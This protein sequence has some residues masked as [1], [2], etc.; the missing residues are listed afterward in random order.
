MSDILEAFLLFEESIK[1]HFIPVQAAIWDALFD[2]QKEKEIHGDL[3]EIGVLSGKSAV[4]LAMNSNVHEEVHLV[5]IKKHEELDASLSKGKSDASG[6]TRFFEMNSQDLVKNSPWGKRNNPYRF[7]H[8]DGEHTIAGITSDLVVADNLLGEKGIVVVDDIFN[9]RYV[10]LTFALMKYILSGESNLI[11]FAIG[12]NKAYMCRPNETKKYF[13]D[14]R[15]K[16]DSTSYPRLTATV[17]FDCATDF[18]P[19]LGLR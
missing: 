15:A 4:F 14:L 13:R 16:L 18:G 17:H 6:Q 3:L 1:G 12:F 11:P 7:I 10:H 2:Y 5:D 19:C 9:E 8:V